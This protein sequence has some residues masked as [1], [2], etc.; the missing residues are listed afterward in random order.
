MFVFIAAL[1]AAWIRGL[2]ITCGCFGG[3]DKGRYAWWLT[4]D[5]ALLVAIVVLQSLW[6]QQPPHSAASPQPES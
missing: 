3:A 4:R 6:Q 1:I 2:D 5:V